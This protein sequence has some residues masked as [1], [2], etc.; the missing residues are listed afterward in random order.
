MPYTY[1]YLVPNLVIGWAFTSLIILEAQFKV[2][3]AAIFN[4]FN[5]PP[6]LYKFF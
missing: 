4:I 3:V 5:F 6:N 1:L 2:V